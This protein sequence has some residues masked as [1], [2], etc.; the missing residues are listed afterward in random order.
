[1]QDPEGSQGRDGSRRTERS[2][3]A[4][5]DLLRSMRKEMNELKNSMKGKMAKN[6]DTFTQRV[7]DH[8]LS[9]KFWLL[10]LESYDEL[11]DPLDHITT[12]KMTL[13]L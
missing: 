12:F 1:M 6:L 5:N 8:P 9:P 10:Q 11:K 3:E 13:S 4:N 2:D 7:L